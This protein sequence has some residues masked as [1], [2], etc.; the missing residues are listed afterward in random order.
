MAYAF[1]TEIADRVLTI[2]TGR[3]A[4]QAN[5]AVTVQYGDTVVL[6][7]AC[8]N[9]EPKESTDFLPLT[10]DYEERLYAAGKIPGS[11][12]RREGRPSTEAILACRLT[13]RPLR[14]LFPKDYRNE[15]QV[16]VTV[17]SADMENDPDI[18]AIIGAS[19]AL[20]ISDIPFGGPVAT[21]RIGYLDG[22]YVVNPTYSQLEHSMLDLVVVG[23]RS[24]TVMVE[25]DGK[26]A[27]ED[28][29][30]GAIAAG[31]RANEDVLKLQEE[32]VAACGRP[33]MEHKPREIDTS[34]QSEVT[35]AIRERIGE[36]GTWKK[37]ADR[38]AAVAQLKQEIEEKFGATQSA[39][40]LASAF[41]AGLK[42]VVR[43]GILERGVRPDGRR[44]DEIRAIS[45]EVG[46][47]PRTHGSG[48]FTRGQTQVLTIATLGSPGEEQQI[49]G[50]G[51]EESKRYMHHYNFPPF[52]NGEVKRLGS[53][54]RREIG[55][56]ALAE[57][58]LIPVLPDEA[59]FPYTIRLVSEVL[60]SNGSTSMASV[61][62]STLAL[63]DAGVPIKAPVAG[64]A[65]GLVMGEDG[66]YVLLTDIQGLEDALGD[67][68][69]KVAG[70]A[71]GITALQMDIKVKSVS[72]EILED[73]LKQAKAARL[74]VLERMKETIA[75]SRPELSKYAPR[76]TKIQVDP[77]K[78]RHVIGPGGK[79]IRAITSEAKVT[80]DIENDG[81]ILIG[82][83]NEDAT[84][85]AIKMIEELTR[86]VEVGGIYTGR[87]T[88]VMNFGAFVEILP[89]K[90]GLVHISELAEHQVANVED[91]V[92]VGDEVTVMVTEIDRMGRINLSRRAV[93]EKDSGVP[94]PQAGSGP[95]SGPGHPPRRRPDSR[96]QGGQRDRERP[97]GGGPRRPFR[98][99]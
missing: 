10:I 82:S 72:R 98:K 16:V 71:E 78:I 69:F 36:E 47:F 12:F 48:L 14:P 35:A 28:V 2:E 97:K 8:A 9:P 20:S 68:D 55:H 61:C 67:M 59:D 5:G 84:Q 41:D 31:Q 62:G 58:A 63:M 60:S 3:F 49:D 24:G 99:D 66:K 23:T 1:Q 94:R 26:E 83:P 87:V 65:M 4:E 30:L 38:R 17:L 80:I 77:D 56:G 50:I 32:L 74:Y 11:F 45:C 51:Q 34:L 73:G 21:C 53:P 18:L 57:R 81:T 25:G 89:G 37:Q 75:T 85:K 79:M 93:F 46:A 15:T 91:V 52:S 19:A 88:R 44:P 70:T 96:H 90:E 33:K 40:D 7:T 6:V 92:K 76:L 29:V 86:D 39:Q 95:R 27:P 64:I 13:D 22:Q 42:D 54:G 43:S